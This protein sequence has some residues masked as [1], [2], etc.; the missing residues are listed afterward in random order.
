MNENQELLEVL[1]VSSPELARLIEAARRAGA[2]GA[3]LSGAGWGGNMIALV[4]SQKERITAVTEALIEAGAT[5]V[6]VTQLK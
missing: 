3:K 6:I 1:R 4:P 2:A 5:G